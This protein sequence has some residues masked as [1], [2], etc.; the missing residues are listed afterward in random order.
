MDRGAIEQTY[1]ALKRIR[2]DA[3]S[4]DTEQAEAVIASL[5]ESLSLA[6]D[7]I[8]AIDREPAHRSYDRA[9]RAEQVVAHH[10]IDRNIVAFCYRV[11]LRAPK[12]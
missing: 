10:M 5:S 9:M 6:L 1:A 7:T 3:P 12:V 2:R 11:H 8:S 4:Y